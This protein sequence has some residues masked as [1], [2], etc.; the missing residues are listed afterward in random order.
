MTSN[1]AN[2]SYACQE[3]HVNPLL[4]PVVFVRWTARRRKQ[5]TAGDTTSKTLCKY[6][7]MVGE[8][9]KVSAA[10]TDAYSTLQTYTALPR[11][12]ECD[13][14]RFII[15]ALGYPA[16]RLCHTHQRAVSC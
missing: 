2:V 5:T 1:A 10:Q 4:A 3:T 13:N 9:C 11:S 14:L 12:E 15:A 8:G 6:D 7:S 16:L